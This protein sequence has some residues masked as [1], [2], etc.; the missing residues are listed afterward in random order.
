MKGIVFGS[1]VVDLMGRSP[2]LPVAGETVKGN[3]F[4]L[5]AGGK[6]FNQ[7]VA[8]H[9]AGADI[10]MITKLG[11]D[12]FSDI[13]LSTMEE[14][15]MDKDYLIFDEE[16]ETGVALIMVDENTSQNKILVIPGACDNIK[17]EE[18]EKLRPVFRDRDYLLLQLETNISAINKVVKMAKEENL[19]IILNPA[20]VQ[21]IDDAVLKE[22]D[23]I[24]PNEVE[25]QI[26]TGIEI[27][28]EE[29][30]K[31]VAEIFFNKGIKKVVITL[32]E[33]GVYVNDKNEEKL[34][35]PYK[36]K[37]LDTT[38]AGDAFNGGLLSALLEEKDIFEAANF[39]NALAALSV[40]RLGTTPAM[41]TREEID[42]FIK[43]RKRC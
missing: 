12:K 39:A 34:I 27:D 16:K 22:I 8:A 13:A 17:D 19:K 11:K 7:G 9:K 30:A 43:E 35:K 28:S 33:R 1:F 26:L 38:G 2:H 24:T 40:E 25:A 21:A 6:G 4:K 3:F 10:K 32:G 23:I 36:V 42:E 15:K 31:K 41:P 29:S 37:V 18:I 14:L 20:P 5:G